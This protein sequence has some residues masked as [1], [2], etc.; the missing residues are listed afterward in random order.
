MHFTVTVDPLPS[1]VDCDLYALL[2]LGPDIF[3]DPYELEQQHWLW[4]TNDLELPVAAVD[5]SGS[6]VLLNLTRRPPPALS[7]PLHARY[8]L[9]GFEQHLAHVEPAR[10]FWACDAPRDEV[11]IDP[12]SDLRV[13]MTSPFSSSVYLY[14]ASAPTAMRTSV[15]IP[16]G[17]ISHWPFVDIATKASVLVMCAYVAWECVRLGRVLRAAKDK[18]D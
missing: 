13:E 10:F 9:P 7:V 18:S 1:G 8:P 17:L 6:A 12:L 11:I 2:E 14:D 4:G 5:P 16:T 3:V 15:G